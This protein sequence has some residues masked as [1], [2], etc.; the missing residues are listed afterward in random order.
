MENKQID[1][2]DI[3]LILTKHKKFIFFTTLI[4]SITAVIFSLVTPEYWVST[5]TILPS[6]EQ[7]ST[8]SLGGA[9]S[10]FGLGSSFLGGSL[11]VNGL[12]F[13][14]IMNSRTF[15]E[16]VIEKYDIVEYFKIEDSDSLV[17]KELALKG[18]RNKIRSIGMDEETGLISISIETKDKFLSMEIANYHWQKLEKYNVEIRMSKGRQ[19]RMFLEKRINEVQDVI[20]ILSKDYLQFQQNN[21]IVEIENQTTM[22]IA[23]YADLIAQKTTKE[24]ELEYSKQIKDVN[25]PIL[26]KLRKEIEIVNDKIAELEISNSEDNKYIL[27]LDDMPELA[28]EYMNLKMNLEIQEQLF[29]F[30][31]PQFEQAKIEEVKDLPTIEVIDRAIPSGLRS[32]PKRAMNCILAFIGA[33]ALSVFY[34]IGIELLKDYMESAK[35]HGKIS[36]IKDNLKIAK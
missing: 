36:Q 23:L 26:N 12:D 7:K 1:I 3:L 31:Y 2:L 33:L 6:Q 35:R 22:L 11:N 4:V 16:D 24:I 25:N 8:F 34:S 17:A 13:I 18:F 19:K 32:K 20:T 14:T 30:L 10:L 28:L 29:S 21:N 5:T 15:S 27:S 9:S